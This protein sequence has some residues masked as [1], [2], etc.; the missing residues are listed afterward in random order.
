MLCPGTNALFDDIPVM[1]VAKNTHQL[2]VRCYQDN[3]NNNKASKI[4]DNTKV[5]Q[6][7]RE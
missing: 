6:S 3:S 7:I 5:V 2:Y 4:I 1:V